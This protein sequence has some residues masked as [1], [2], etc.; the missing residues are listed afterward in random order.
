MNH[1]TWMATGAALVALV[2][3]DYKAY[4]GIIKELGL[5]KSQQKKS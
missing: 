4:E 2:E 5:H 1:R 3:R